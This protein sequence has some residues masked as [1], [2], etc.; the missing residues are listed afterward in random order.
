MIVAA[1]AAAT[2]M[3]TKWVKLELDLED[4]GKIER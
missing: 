1:A 3:V 2:T 4:T